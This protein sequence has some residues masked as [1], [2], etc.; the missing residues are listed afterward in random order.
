MRDL[1]V[2][3]V[4]KVLEGWEKDDG[5]WKQEMCGIAFLDE[6]SEKRKT[7]NRSWRY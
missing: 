1:V 2:K 5:F 4:G 7:Y 6:T 3:M